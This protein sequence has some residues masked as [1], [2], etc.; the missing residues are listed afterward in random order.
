MLIKINAFFLLTGNTSH[1][2]NICVFFSKIHPAPGNTSRHTAYIKPSANFKNHFGRPRLWVHCY[3]CRARPH[4]CATLRPHPGPHPKKNTPR[5]W[6][7]NLTLNRN[8]QHQ[9]TILFYNKVEKFPHPHQKTEVYI[10]F[11]TG[12][13][14]VFQH[15]A[16]SRGLSPPLPFPPAKEGWQGG[17]G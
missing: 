13:L 12:T 8:S 17:L 6:T 4:H 2:G 3:F 5:P 14:R 11:T 10:S 7:P 15:S 16:E 1:T 9:N